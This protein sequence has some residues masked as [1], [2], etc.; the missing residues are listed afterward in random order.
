MK[1]HLELFL[2][3][4][5]HFI[6]PFT[7]TFGKKGQ[8]HCI[9]GFSF[10]GQRVVNGRVLPAGSWDYLGEVR[11]EPGDHIAVFPCQLFGPDDGRFH[12]FCFHY[13]SRSI[14]GTTNTTAKFCMPA[15][16]KGSFLKD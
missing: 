11:M 3:N 2:E 9:N 8:Y 5:I 16:Q 6:C 4:R 10:K 12:T 13:V 14:I 15:N 1:K 7:L